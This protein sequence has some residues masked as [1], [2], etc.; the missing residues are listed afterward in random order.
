MDNL[1]EREDE[2]TSTSDI[3]R[4]HVLPVGDVAT[5]HS[6]LASRG[7]RPEACPVV[8]AGHVSALGGR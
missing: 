6:A 1:K 4:R 7:I 3:L 2:C 8:V 5:L